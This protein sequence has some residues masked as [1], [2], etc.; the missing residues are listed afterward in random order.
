[1]LLEH[2]CHRSLHDCYK[3]LR[4]H[5]LVVISE[6]VLGGVQ[7]INGEQKICFPNY[8]RLLGLAL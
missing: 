2:H 7:P 5:R 1:M 4:S 6:I 8:S 3:V